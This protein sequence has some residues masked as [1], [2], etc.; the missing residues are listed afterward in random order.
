MRH[1]R[2]T[3]KWVNDTK[4]EGEWQYN[5]ACGQGTFLTADGD[6]YEGLW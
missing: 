6:I 2:G 1:G 4:Y 5:Q 3:M